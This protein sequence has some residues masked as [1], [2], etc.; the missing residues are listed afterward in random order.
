MGLKSRTGSN[1]VIGTIE[2]RAPAGVLPSMVPLPNFEPVVFACK[3]KTLAILCGFAFH[4]VGRELTG[5]T[6]LRV[7]RTRSSAPRCER[8]G[9]FLQSTPLPTLDRSCLLANTQL[10][11]SAGVSYILPS[12]ESLPVARACA[13]VEPG[14]WH[15]LRS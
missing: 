14:H 1:P 8:G 15:S 4:S 7:R 10:S 12:G 9:A 13:R 5:S 2:G 11:P 3:H 6:R